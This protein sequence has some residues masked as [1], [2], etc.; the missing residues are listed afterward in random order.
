M[1]EMSF[2]QILELCL[3]P[4]GRNRWCQLPCSEHLNHH[5]GRDSVEYRMMSY[6]IHNGVL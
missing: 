1:R 2:E 3:K 4:N 6:G 5:H